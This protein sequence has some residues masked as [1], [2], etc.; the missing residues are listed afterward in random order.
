MARVIGRVSLASY[1]TG[2]LSYLPSPK[3]G[4]GY[5]KIRGRP[6]TLASSE[7]ILAHYIYETHIALLT[8]IKVGTL[9]NPFFW[10]KS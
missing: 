4:V 7:M 9:D 2:T 1:T 5:E 3:R 6:H 8:Y 10:N